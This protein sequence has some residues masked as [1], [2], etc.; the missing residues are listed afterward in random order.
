MVVC[1]AETA[2]RGRRADSVVWTT[3]GRQREGCGRR[4]A[5]AIATTAVATAPATSSWNYWNSL[6]DFL[7]TLKPFRRTLEDLAIPYRNYS[8]KLLATY[9][10]SHPASSPYPAHIRPVVHRSMSRPHPVHI[11][12]VVYIRPVARRPHPVHIRPVVHR[13]MSRPHPVPIRQPVYIRPVARRRHPAHIRPVVHR[14]RSRS[15]PVHI[16]LVVHRSMSL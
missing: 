7:N 15:H 3:C 9:G 12:Q 11:R 2:R 13:S 5:T 6:L 1:W 14:S 10:L 16:R 8:R 4:H